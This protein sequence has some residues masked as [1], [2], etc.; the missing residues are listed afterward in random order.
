[1]N[2]VINYDVGRTLYAQVDTETFLKLVS[3]PQYPILRAEK[4]D[5]VCATRIQISDLFIALYPPDLLREIIK[6]AQ[7]RNF[8][9]TDMVEIFVA[10][11]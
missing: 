4:I 8:E 5:G 9:F 2:K 1:M 10:N 7:D 6:E 11:N 3:W